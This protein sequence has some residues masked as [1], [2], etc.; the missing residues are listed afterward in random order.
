MFSPITVASPCSPVILCAGAD[1]TNQPLLHTLPR[2]REERLRKAVQARER[3]EQMEE[4]KKKRMEQ[5]ILQNDDKVRRLSKLRTTQYSD[6][7][8]LTVT[9]KGCRQATGMIHASTGLLLMVTNQV[10]GKSTSETLKFC[11]TRAGFCSPHL[12]SGS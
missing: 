12:C 5:K 9:P 1:K 7:F 6:I 10:V 3:V 4:E 2:K 8:S 11:L